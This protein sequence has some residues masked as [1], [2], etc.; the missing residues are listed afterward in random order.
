MSFNRSLRQAKATNTKEYVQQ[1]KVLPYSVS[2]IGNKQDLIAWRKEQEKLE[3]AWV[4]RRAD[5][6]ER[7]I[8]ALMTY[9]APTPVLAPVEPPKSWF[10]KVKSAAAKWF[11]DVWKSACGA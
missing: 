8:V 1:R 7:A 3:Q 11:T 4:E 5:R 2:V 10:Q 6:R 9:R